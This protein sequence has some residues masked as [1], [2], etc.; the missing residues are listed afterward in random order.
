MQQLA[1]RFKGANDD[2]CIYLVDVELVFGKLSEEC[3]RRT[4]P[5]CRGLA[6]SLAIE[7][8]TYE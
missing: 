2:R 4:I 3:P 8:E 1:D 7:E 5:E 6:T